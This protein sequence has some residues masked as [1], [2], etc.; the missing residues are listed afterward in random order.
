MLKTIQINNQDLG[1]GA[2]IDTYGTFDGE[3]IDDELIDDYNETHGVSLC[4]DDFEWEYDHK[5]I[6]AEIAEARAKELVEDVDCIESIKVL[7]SGS[8][9]YYNFTTDWFVGEYTIDLDKLEK[10]ISEHKKEFEPWYQE[11]WVITVENSRNDEEKAESLIMAKLD[12]IINNVVHDSN[13]VGEEAFNNLCEA[14][15]EI[16]L[17][18]TKMELKENEDVNA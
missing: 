17:N 13:Y 11:H 18:N 2:T 9:A 12:F 15:D 4:Y 3:L 1:L 14:V 5:Q 6:V 7:R 8:P 16:Y 10:T